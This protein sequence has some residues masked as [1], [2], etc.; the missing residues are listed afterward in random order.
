MFIFSVESHILIE[1]NSV[2]SGNE[3]YGDDDNDNVFI[4]LIGHAQLSS[5][6]EKRKHQE[7]NLVSQMLF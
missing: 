3:T 6:R 7:Q 1:T 5:F 2:N 4:K